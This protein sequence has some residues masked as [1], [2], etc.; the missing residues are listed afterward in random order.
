MKPFSAT[1]N[2][3]KSELTIASSRGRQ[4]RGLHCSNLL[5]HK[6]K[7]LWLIESQ[8]LITMTYNIPNSIFM[9]M[10]PSKYKIKYDLIYQTECCI[11]AFAL[12]A[13]V[14]LKS[15]MFI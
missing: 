2:W 8:F 12:N 9:T 13:P 1:L 5:C 6:N 14:G 4:S 15:Q 10:G 3:A 7:Y 11:C